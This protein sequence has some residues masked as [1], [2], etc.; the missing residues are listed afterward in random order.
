MYQAAFVG[1]V[2]LAPQT[3]RVAGNPFELVSKVDVRGKESFHRR[4]LNDR[5]KPAIVQDS[6]I[7][8]SARAAHRDCVA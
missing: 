4:A 5:W 7:T 6:A 3:K 8:L 1:V 2:F